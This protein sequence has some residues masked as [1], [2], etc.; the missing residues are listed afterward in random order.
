MDQLVFVHGVNTRKGE[1]YD[2]EVDNRDRLFKE[3]A[4]AGAPVNIRNVYWGD[5]GAQ[6]GYDLACLPSNGPKAASFGLLGS[7]ATPATVLQAQPLSGLAS[8]DFGAMVDAIFVAL[9]D[10]AEAAGKPLTGDQI[11]KFR[12][13]GDYAVNN[14]VAAPS[15]ASGA[16]SDQ[17]IVSELRKR[18]APTAA[19]SFG[20]SDDIASAAKSLADRARNLVSSGIAPIIRDGASPLV[21]RFLGD[22]FVYLYDRG[23]PS[24]RVKIREIIAN[25]VNAAATEAKKQGGKVVL[26]GHSL[27]GVI[28]RDMLGDP[29]SGLDQNIRIDLL[30]TVGS[31][32]GLFQEMSLLGNLTKAPQKVSLVATVGSWWNVYDPVDLL[33]F[34][35]APMFQD[36]TDFE[37]SSV[38]GLIDAHTS[39]FKR[40]RFYARLRERLKEIGIGA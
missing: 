35:C 11:A 9:I 18:V 27:G 10:E 12:T 37:F 33:S 34:R 31:Q 23:T 22:I 19:V 13:A 2:L 21:A 15:W 1:G 6:F 7:V 26:I 40:P 32:P 3:A 8:T 14:A 38:A 29:L 20:L 25:D 5:L 39:Y 4:W 24:K 36:V 16:S 17:L 28:L 30:A